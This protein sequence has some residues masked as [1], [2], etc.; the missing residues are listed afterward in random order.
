MMNFARITAGSLAFAMCVAGGLLGAAEQD[1]R[2]SASG[3]SDAVETTELRA[4]LEAEGI[5]E[6]VGG[7]ATAPDEPVLAEQACWQE[8]CG[9]PVSASCAPCASPQIGCCQYGSFVAAFDFAVLSAHFEDNRA[10]TVMES[11][12]AT[13]Q[14]FSDTEF[15]YKLELTPRVWVGFESYSGLGLRAGYWHYDHAPA[16]VSVSPPANGLGRIDHPPFGNVDIS[17]TIPTDT[18]TAATDLDAFVIDFEVTKSIAFGSWSMQVSGGL[19]YASIEQSYLAGLENGA[20]VAL[21]EI[22]FSHRVQGAGPTAS[23]TVFRPI[24]PGTT[25]FALARGSLL[26]GE[27]ESRLDAG[28][29]LNVAPFYTT[30]VTQRDDVLPIGEIQI[31]VQWSGYRMPYGGWT[32]FLRLA[33]ESQ[34]WSGAGSASSEDGD[35]EFVGF[36]AGVGCVW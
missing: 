16:V 29:N 8:G 11:D 32:P 15:D 20:G 12:G 1:K 19:R 7:L 14:A 23:L 13:F 9:E 35:L 6:V 31:G 28:D 24:S 5:A 34:L 4:P 2:F 26:Y 33:A 22:N 30:R 18:F 17:S 21:G 36:S 27:G 10:F 25:L 3:N